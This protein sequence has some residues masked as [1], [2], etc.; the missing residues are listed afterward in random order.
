MTSSRERQLHAL[1][2]SFVSQPFALARLVNS[3]GSVVGAVF[4]VRFVAAGVAACTAAGC[5]F[6]A[7]GAATDEGAATGA[8]ACV[9]V[10]SGC[11]FGAATD[12]GAV[13]GAAA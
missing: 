11:C 5:C 13:T 12:E 1:Y 6:G 7:G 8:A 9:S 4:S 2:C 3:S 10:V